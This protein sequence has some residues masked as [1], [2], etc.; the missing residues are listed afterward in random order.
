MLATV[1]WSYFSVLGLR[2]FQVEVSGLGLK[3]SG[4]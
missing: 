4:L 2:P 1:Y 3:V